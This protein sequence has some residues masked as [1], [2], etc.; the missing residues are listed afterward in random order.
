MDTK[1]LNERLAVVLAQLGITN[2]EAKNRVMKHTFNTNGVAGG[3]VDIL[4]NNNKRQIGVS[5]FDG[6]KLPKGHYIVINAIAAHYEDTAT[7]VAAAT[8]EDDPDPIIL[9]SNLVVV[10]GKTVIETA[11]KPLFNNLTAKS[12]PQQEFF[13]LA[14]GNV[15]VPDEEFLMQLNVPK[16]TAIAANKFLGLSFNV[17]HVIDKSVVKT[18]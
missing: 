11:L 12:S 9:N 1:F 10:Q 5:D 18:A 14:D 6:N 15:I 17:F 8:W 4:D 7:T 2:F 16:G 13:P 3:L